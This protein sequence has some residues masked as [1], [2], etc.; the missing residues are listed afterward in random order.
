MVP[1]HWPFVVQH[2]NCIV[3]VVSSIAP[4]DGLGTLSLLLLATTKLRR[5]LGQN[6][7]IVQ[8]DTTLSQSAE[9]NGNMNTGYFTMTDT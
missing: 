5:K 1:A 4:W 9:R 6:D 7:P 8:L 2:D 3:N